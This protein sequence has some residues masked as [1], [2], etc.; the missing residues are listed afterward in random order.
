M[1]A[2]FLWFYCLPISQAL[3]LTALAALVF[4]I[5]REAA[6][7]TASWK[8]AVALLL[9]LWIAV[10]LYGTLGQ[11]TEGENLR[12]PIPVPFYSYYSVFYGGSKE[13]LRTNFMNA[14]LF[15]PAGLLGCSLLPGRR[16]QNLLAV[17]FVLALMS[18]GIEYVQFRF[19]MGLAETDD[20]IHNTLGALLGALTSGMSFKFHFTPPRN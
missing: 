17:T 7:H 20:V 8:A 10:I 14:A 3:A 1:R 18:I 6:G 12:D 13:L 16:S 11:R 4:L 5:V 15:F 9:V 19:G 2:V